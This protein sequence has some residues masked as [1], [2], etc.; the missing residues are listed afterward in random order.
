MRRITGLYFRS[1]F[2]YSNRA[3]Y[4]EVDYPSSTMAKTCH[5]PICT[6]V[7][8]TPAPR[9]TIR[10]SRARVYLLGR[11]EEQIIRDGRFSEFG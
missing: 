10:R 11:S 8:A 9:Y 1:E 2:A 4:P 3:I 7:S 6:E 5:T